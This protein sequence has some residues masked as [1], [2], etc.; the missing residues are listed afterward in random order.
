MILAFFQALS[1]N[2]IGKGVDRGLLL[3]KQILH[4]KG[5]LHIASKP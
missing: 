2:T 5:E 3:A 4:T 1:G